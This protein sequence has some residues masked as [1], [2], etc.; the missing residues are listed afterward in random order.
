MLTDNH[1]IIFENEQSKK[2]A[3]MYM[4]IYI[5]ASLEAYRI[6]AE[7]IGSTVLHNMY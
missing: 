3:I 2:F 5:V 6:Y 7:A 1:K 4:Y